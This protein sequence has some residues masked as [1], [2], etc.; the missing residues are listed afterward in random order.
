MGR[1][2]GARG[3]RSSSTNYHSAANGFAD[4]KF[5]FADI[6]DEPQFIELPDDFETDSGN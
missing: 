4:D 2:K 6:D 5:T 1:S 3:G